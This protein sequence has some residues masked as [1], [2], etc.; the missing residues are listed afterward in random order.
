MR[1]MIVLCVV[2]TASTAHARE[3]GFNTV[4]LGSSLVDNVAGWIAR[5][6][7]RVDFERPSEDDS[8]SLF[9]MRA[10]LEFWKAGERWGFTT[11]IGYYIGAQVDHT[12]TT[13]GGG[14][15]LIHMEGGPKF[16]GG[17]APFLSGSLEFVYDG[18]LLSV[19]ARLARDVIGE[20][21]DHNTYSVMLMVGKK[22]N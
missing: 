18:V 3:G 22:I 15:S 20:A 10:G 14:F 2:G 21:D 11:P 8:G 12:R 1:W 9:G 7:T 17:I 19:D 13:L 4:G 16:T 6:E 5:A